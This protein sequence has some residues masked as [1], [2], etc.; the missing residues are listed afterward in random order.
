[1]A[2]SQNHANRLIAVLWL[3]FVVFL[4]FAP[5]PVK[6]IFFTRGVAHPWEHLMAFLIAAFLLAI[7]DVVPLIMVCG[8]SIALGIF[9]EVSQVV[10]YHNRFEYRD[11]LLDVAGAAFGCLIARALRGRAIRRRLLGV[12]R[13]I[14]R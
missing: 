14:T 10:I 12:R 9:L 3:V 7:A 11:L 1:M 2:Q 5:V 8:A 4:S 6:D 13:I